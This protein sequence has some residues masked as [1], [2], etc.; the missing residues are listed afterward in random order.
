[1]YY[2]PRT[3]YYLQLTTHYSL[4]TTTYDRPCY[5]A[6]VLLTVG[7][8][9]ASR[10]RAATAFGYNLGSLLRKHMELGSFVK[11]LISYSQV[12]AC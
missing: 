2:L 10:R 6:Q 3:T 4:L 11:Q 9:V 5:G 1:M 12:G 8:L 7:W